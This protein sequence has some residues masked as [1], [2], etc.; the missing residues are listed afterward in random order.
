M[1]LIHHPDKGSVSKKS[2]ADKFSVIHQ[3]YSVLSKPE[4]RCKYDAEG[5]EVIFARATSIAAEW[6]NFLKITTADQINNA[7][8]TY[9]GSADEKTDILKEFVNGKGSIIHVLNTVPFI[10]KEDAWRIIDI[11]QRAILS[12]EIPHFPIKKLPKNY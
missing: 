4:L 6:E 11:V 3:A 9:K 1:A 7:A 10:R 8:D 2:S 12:E 5:S